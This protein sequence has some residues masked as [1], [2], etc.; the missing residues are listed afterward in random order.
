VFIQAGFIRVTRSELLSQV[1]NEEYILI[2]QLLHLFIKE[3]GTVV[4]QRLFVMYHHRIA[5]LVSDPP[6]PPDKLL[7]L[8]KLRRHR[9]NQ[10]VDSSVGLYFL[11]GRKVNAAPLLLA[12]NKCRVSKRV[13]LCEAINC[14]S[15]LG[16]VRGEE[17]LHSYLK[18]SQL[19][20]KGV[21]GFVHNN[22]DRGLQRFLFNQFGYGIPVIFY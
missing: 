18:P 9:G 22:D 2:A 17:D 5:A 20:R 6:C 12:Y 13:N 10:D 19:S 16:G 8:Q 14:G 3:H 11:C 1:F 4:I 21:A 15:Y 7:E